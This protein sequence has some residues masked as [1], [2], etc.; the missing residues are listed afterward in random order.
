MVRH[1]RALFLFFPIVFGFYD[2]IQ[3]VAVNF[4]HHNIDEGGNI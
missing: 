3:E 2:E 1:I 4:D